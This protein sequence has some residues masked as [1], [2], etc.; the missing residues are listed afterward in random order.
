MHVIILRKFRQFP[1]GS[2]QRKSRDSRV[3]SR[4]GTGLYFSSIGESQKNIR[5]LVSH[6]NELSRG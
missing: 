5:N 1:D 4:E 2:A 6:G 3:E